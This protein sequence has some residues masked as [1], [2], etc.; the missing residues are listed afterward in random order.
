ME[1]IKSHYDW[2]QKE[3]LMDEECMA[4]EEEGF[5]FTVEEEEEVGEE[6]VKEELAYDEEA[7]EEETWEEEMEEVDGSAW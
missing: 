4:E 6:D 5:I 3:Q 2:H 1:Y 7:G